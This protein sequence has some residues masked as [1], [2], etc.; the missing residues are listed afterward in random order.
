ML[1]STQ[2]KAIYSFAAQDNIPSGYLKSNTLNAIPNTNSLSTTTDLKITDGWI[3]LKILPFRKEY[4]D[5]ISPNSFLSLSKMD[6]TQLLFHIEHIPRIIRMYIPTVEKFY[7]IN[8]QTWDSQYLEFELTINLTKNFRT[9]NNDGIGDA[10]DLFNSQYLSSGGLLY[11]LRKQENIT[12]F[13]YSLEN[14]APW[15]LYSDSS[16]FTEPYAYS[17]IDGLH[18]LCS[19]KDAESGSD[20]QMNLIYNVSNHLKGLKIH[21]EMTYTQTNNSPQNPPIIL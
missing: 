17:I 16:L 3:S 2:K 21:L 12:A 15:S 5:S 9:I 13:E 14:Q 19:I 18:R 4:S 11:K 20:P 1:P 7:N 8:T 6:Q 10:R